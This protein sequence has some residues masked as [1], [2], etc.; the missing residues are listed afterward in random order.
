MEDIKQKG[1]NLGQI[2]SMLAE[3]EN[4]TADE[5]SN[6]T[7][8]L[9][10]SETKYTENDNGI[11]VKVNQLSLETIYKIY[12]YVLEVR[13][14][15]EDLETAIKSLETNE[16]II[17]NSPSF[18][19]E[20]N[21]NENEVQNTLTVPEWKKEIIEKMQTSVKNKGKKRTKTTKQTVET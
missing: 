9:K 14:T 7:I 21:N 3:I 17:N 4:M 19:N 11:F 20:D 16:C 8:I 12:N 5:H 2:K 13:R 1:L 10:E 6:I 18:I 15:K